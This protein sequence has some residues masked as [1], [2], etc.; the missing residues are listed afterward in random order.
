VK[1]LR[2][3]VP[4]GAGETP[5]GLASRLAALNGLPARDF[6]LDFGTTFQAVVDGDPAAIAVVAAK[7]GVDP[8]VLGQHAFL[9][10]GER[11]YTF[12]GEVLVRSSLRRAAVAVSP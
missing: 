9:R 2:H 12:R 1:P 11:R 3:T 7:G 10:I 5:A 6:C 4:L 8:G